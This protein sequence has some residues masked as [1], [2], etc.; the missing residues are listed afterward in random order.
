MY[1]KENS[2]GKKFQGSLINNNIIH[3]IKQIKGNDITLDHRSVLGV[4][5]SCNV[6]TELFVSADIDHIDQP[7]HDIHN[8]L[9]SNS[10]PLLTGRLYHWRL[11]TTDIS[12]R[13]LLSCMCLLCII[14]SKMS[15]TA[16][17][18]IFLTQSDTTVAGTH[19]RDRICYP[20]RWLFK[21]MLPSREQFT[22]IGISPFVHIFPRYL[23]L[24]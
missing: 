4:I 23:L 5:V 6:E 19:A 16:A 7:T 1:I 18:S 9:N 12:I 10:T 20:W 11:I 14:K 17:P 8:S 2:Q 13:V 21:D 15:S 24:N 3:D 22:K